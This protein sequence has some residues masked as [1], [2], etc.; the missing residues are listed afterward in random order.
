MGGDSGRVGWERDE[1]DGGERKVKEVESEE[2]RGGGSNSDGKSGGAQP[3]TLTKADF[4][5]TTLHT[6]KYLG[7]RFRSIIP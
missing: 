1:G 5:S 6:R 4:P 2:G 7:P 3:A